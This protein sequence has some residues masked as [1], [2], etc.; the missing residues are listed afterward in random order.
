MRT[1]RTRNDQ[2]IAFLTMEDEFGLFE[3]TIFPDAARDAACP[4]ATGRPSSPPSWRSSTTRSRCGPPTSPNARCYWNAGQLSTMTRTT[5]S[6][7]GHPVSGLPANTCQ[8]STPNTSSAP[9]ATRLPT[10]WARSTRPARQQKDMFDL[11]AARFAAVELNFTFYNARPRRDAGAHE[12]Q[13]P[14]GFSVLGEGQPG[15][16]AQGQPGRGQGVP[17]A[18]RP[19]AGLRQARG[20]AAPVPPVLPPHRRGPAVPRRPR[21]RPWRRCRWRWSSAISSWDHPATAERPD[22][23]GTWRW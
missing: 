3:V 9:A 6:V 23:S 11:Y 13:G 4:A 10:G 15:I 20:P 18:G 1:A 12:R 21:W 22:A 16:D 17:G 8:M 14:G 5:D 7:T 2:T 19:D